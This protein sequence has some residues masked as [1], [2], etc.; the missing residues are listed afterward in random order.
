[1]SRI[2]NQLQ[3][4]T[5]L[6]LCLERLH[7]NDQLEKALLLL[8]R[9][10]DRLTSLRLEGQD[11]RI[12]LSRIANTFSSKDGFPVLEEFF[13]VWTRWMSNIECQWIVSMVSIR[14]RPRIPLKV[15][16]VTDGYI[17]E[18][19]WTPV[20]RAID[21]STIEELHFTLSSFRQNHLELLVDRIANSAGKSLLPLRVLEFKRAK[22][23]D[24]DTTRTILARVREKAPKVEI[25][26]S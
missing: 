4:L 10:K 21:L 23:T 19:D 24:N 3:G 12:W 1:M 26:W 5:Y 8:K 20:I 15:F 22:I 7:L 6:R 11:V 13:G 18:H 9:H 25:R 14:P 2:I 17:H 16:G